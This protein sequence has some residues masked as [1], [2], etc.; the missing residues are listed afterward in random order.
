MW[1]SGKRASRANVPAPGAAAQVDD[2][3]GVRDGEPVDDAGGVVGEE[4]GVEV[5]DLGLV[6]DP[7]PCPCPCP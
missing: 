7:W 1:A 5:E 2:L 3:A 6:V 4:F